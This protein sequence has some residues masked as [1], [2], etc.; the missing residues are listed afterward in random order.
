MPYKYKEVP[1]F[2]STFL[3]YIRHSYKY[4][5]FALCL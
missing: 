2:K 5:E 4:K 3:I 1:H